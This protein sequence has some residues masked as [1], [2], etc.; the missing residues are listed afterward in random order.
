MNKII[1]LYQA[2][3][4]S[5]EKDRDE[6]AILKFIQEAI[7]SGNSAFHADVVKRYME[8]SQF[9]ERKIIDHILNMEKI[10]LDVEYLSIY[11]KQMNAT[12]SSYQDDKAIIVDELWSFTL[13]SFFLTVFSLA[14]DSGTEN[15]SRCIKNCFV[16]LDLQGQ[17]H[18]IGIHNLNDIEQ[19]I[20]LPPNI[21]HLAMDSF[22]T[23]WTFVIGHE[24]YH[25]TTNSHA[26]SDVQEELDADSYGYKIL[27]EMIEAQ[28]KMNIPA[29][30][31]VFYEDYYLAPVML[32]E[33]YRFLDHYRSLCGEKVIYT[34]YPSP[35]Q[36]Q[37]HIFS[38]FDN[39]LPDTF[40]TTTGNE[41]LNHFLDA[42]DLLWEQIT[43]K[44]NYGKLTSPILPPDE[45]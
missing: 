6:E 5:H 36:R 41:L 37:E 29:E 18:R 20:S 14:Y 24:L 32:F 22:W 43:L 35:Q 19:M 33:Y 7:Q 23:A 28:K 10:H 25:L 2:F 11:R 40:D 3:F 9:V 12:C 39:Y 15:F 30:I 21:M 8:N 4:S 45:F 16:L 34:D 1:N 38:L 17:K 31:K 26:G 44:K 42:A 27:I 13:L